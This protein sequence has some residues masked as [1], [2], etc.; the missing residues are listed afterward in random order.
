MVKFV[1]TH[2]GGK[3]ESP[4][5]EPPKEK[6]LGEVFA[7]APTSVLTNDFE[8]RVMQ[9]NKHVLL[10]FYAPWCGWCK[11]IAPDFI[12]ATQALQGN[13]EVELMVVDA[14]QHQ[15]THPKV[16]IQGFPTIFLFKK[17]DKANPVEY[18]GDRSLDDMVN[19]VNIQT[20]SPNIQLKVQEISEGNGESINITN[21]FKEL[22]LDSSEDVIVMFYAP[23]CGWCKKMLPDFDRLAIHFKDYS[24][25]LK[26]MKIDAATYKVEHENIKIYGFPLVNYFKAGNKQNPVEYKGNRT[27]DDMVKYINSNKT[28]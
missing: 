19:F 21:N 12:K 20:N 6:E 11:R 8:P 27:F 13:S 10:L 7:E 22:V 1:N 17:D 14:T 5:Q 28:F 25:K 15:V 24:T 26:V 23:W 9:N 2:T 16:Q 18:N 3:V 4:K